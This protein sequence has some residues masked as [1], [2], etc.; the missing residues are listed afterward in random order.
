MPDTKQKKISF[1]EALI[2]VLFLIIVLT[3]NVRPLMFGDEATSGPNQFALLLAGAIAALIGFKYGLGYE[4]MLEKVSKNIQ[5]TS[6]AILILLFVGALSGTWLIS[7]I[8]PTMVY[9]GLQLLNPTIFLVS[10]LVISAI[11]SLII[12][13]SWS[14]TAT[15]GIAL[16]GIGKALGFPIEMVAGAVIS[17]A[18]FGDKMSPLSD[19]T[20]LASA[21]AEV[22]LYKHV[23][24]MMYT[25]IP[26]FSV[27]LIVFAILGFTHSGGQMQDTSSLLK[28]IES[29][30]TI[31][32]L[33]L[34]VP[35]IVIFLIIKKT[36]PLV[37]L[38]AGVILGGLVALFFQTDILLQQV[39]G[40]AGSIAKSYK[41]IT[42]AI[43]SD[44]QIQTD[45][46]ILYDLFS[47]GGM[48][49]MLNTIW[50]IITAMF[51]GGVMEAI[52]ALKKI[53]ET[54]L[55]MFKS[56]FG[57]FLS[58]DLTC[59]L[60][61][62]TASDQYLAI[63]VPGKMYKQ[64]FDDAGL[65][66][67]NLS[68]TIED[69]GTVTSVLIPWNTG[70]AYNAKVLGVPTESYAIYAVFNWLSPIMTLVFAYFRIK[71]KKISTLN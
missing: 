27:A 42:Q 4:Y 33:L 16:I 13:S 19:T 61:N 6:G 71:I 41:A 36:P 63:V 5:S 48:A 20:N 22:D 46:K 18:Y 62:A 7:G 1:F 40:D 59:I 54:L 60:F 52:G 30:F 64:A 43:V 53:S 24:Y 49:G 32:P 55:G 15:V 2:P 17:G 68:R 50:L 23:R 29:V 67:E 38:L 12:G 26:T 57:L 45:N 21:I 34:L 56:V 44:V 65:A 3:I 66:P 47:S 31:S 69:S 70:G 11:V 58:T 9:Y 39:N 28:D 10:A 14:T 8:I 25:T 37:A 51:F 35:A